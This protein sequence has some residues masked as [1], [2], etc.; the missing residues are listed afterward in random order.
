[1]SNDLAIV[2]KQL[3]DSGLRPIQ[4]GGPLFG[5]LTPDGK[6]LEAVLTNVGL[7]EKAGEI[8]EIQGKF[9]TTAKGFQTLNRF[10]GVS[11]VTPKRLEV[12][13]EGKEMSVPN[14]YPIIDPMSGAIDKVWVR[15]TAIGY[16]PLGTLVVTSASLL[17]DIRMYFI[18]EVIKKIKYNK[19]AGR[20][21]YGAMLTEDEKR[22]GLFERFQGDLG[23]WADLGHKE[24]F[25]VIENLTNRKLFAERNAQ[26]IG[27]RL[28]L[29]QQPA[30]AFPYVTE[31]ITHGEKGAH[32]ASVP[33]WGY[34]SDLTRDQLQTIAEQAE[35]GEEIRVPGVTV[36][37]HEVQATA[38]EIAMM[39]SVEQE[40]DEFA[41][42][43]RP[44]KQ[45]NMYDDL[46]KGL[47]F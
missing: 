13:Y 36:E 9:M 47:D 17:Y 19:D 15:Q 6:R 11:I 4:A 20:I 38:E 35:N 12:V 7:S 3:K 1:M 14:P 21:C 34:R 26:T 32:Y 18:Q 27:K 10:A 30:L 43:D 8:A 23:V 33:I 44:G 25:P 29:S 45:S 41:A 31:Y 40:N 46:D 42:Q 22:K 39:A 37:Q 2:I 5:K 28:V 24:I 16:S